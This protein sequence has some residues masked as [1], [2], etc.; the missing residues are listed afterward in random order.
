MTRCMKVRE[1]GNPG[2]QNQGTEMTSSLEDKQ[3]H[4]SVEKI[5]L[6]TL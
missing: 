2:V 3:S 4:K 6:V 5:A 1:N